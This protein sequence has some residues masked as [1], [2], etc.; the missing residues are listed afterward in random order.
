M[1]E[2]AAPL[3]ATTKADADATAQESFRAP[4]L[5]GLAW[6]TATRV[7][8]EVTKLVVAV[9][10]ARLLTP[11][12]YGLAGM[13][14]VLLAFQPALSGTAFASALVQK[15]EVT[16][17]DRSTVFWTSS[18]TGLFFTLLGLALA[19]PVADFYGDPDVAPLFAAMSLCFFISALGITHTQ[20]MVRDMNFRALEIRS[21]VGVV[22]GAAVAIWAAI[23]GYGAWALVLQP[24]AGFTI[25]TVLLWTMSDWHPRFAFSRG[26]LR[27][28]RRFGGN[29]SVTLFLMQLNQN[30][31]N[32]LV[33]RFL[34]A[35]ALGT[36]TLAYNIILLPFNRLTSP[37]HEVLYPVFSRLQSDRERLASMWLRAVR[38]LAAACVPAMLA[39]IVLAPDVV[40][41]VFGGQWD[42][43]VPVVQIL[44]WVGILL[45]LEG[46]NSLVLMAGARTDILVRFAI[47]NFAAA[48]ISFAV[49]LSAGVVG[50]AAC[51]AV[52]LTVMQL[53][54][55]KLTAR[56]AGTGV[57]AY[58]GAVA[59]VFQASLL[60]TAAV[61]AVRELLAAAEAPPAL[62]IA[63]ATLAGIA[64]YLPAVA[65][66]SRPVVDELRAL[67]RRRRPAAPA[68]A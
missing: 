3:P 54:Y 22:F 57:R 18:A 60:A 32:V 13:V 53:V 66:R 7:L 51:Y 50:I 68:P 63:G 20:L 49:G 43:A 31:N 26:S 28:V 14:L 12:E 62:L 45:A 65:W 41:F 46:L 35:A 4:V 21:M 10:V 34:G 37:L 24:V 9:V 47:A 36:Y 44:A 1:G 48:L 25:S 15:R 27:Q 38:V 67:I 58:A 64:V 29:L 17:A 33:G 42:E 2:M 59:G 56:E 52:V 23:A 5:R 8:F 30:T 39:L 19:G 40:P 55:L 61:A 6:K 11:H 16:E